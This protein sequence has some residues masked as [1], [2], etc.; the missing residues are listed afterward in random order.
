[1]NNVRV[2]SLEHFEPLLN[3]NRWTTNYT[4]STFAGD[5]VYQIIVYNGENE[6]LGASIPR[7][8]KV[9]EYNSSPPVADLLEFNDTS[10]STTSIKRITAQGQDFDGTLVGIQFYV[11]GVP[12]GDEILRR[13]NVSQDMAKYTVDLVPEKSGVVSVF[14]I[15]RD[16]SNNYVASRV[17]TI[18]VTPGSTSPIISLVHGGP[19]QL[20]LSSSDLN[21]EVH[22]FS[23]SIQSVT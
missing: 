17:Q 13:P 8:I 3:S 6:Q 14:V 22:D 19:E 7:I 23:G 5:Y 2:A 11:D 20:H 1:M 18:S 21:I 10:M 16:N 9:S 4:T 15:A 12:Y